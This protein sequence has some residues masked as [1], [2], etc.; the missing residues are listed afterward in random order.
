MKRLISGLIAI[1]LLATI[2][3]CSIG[4]KPGLPVSHDLGPI[5]EQHEDG[6][7]LTLNAPVWLWDERIRYRLLY[8][9]ATVIR[10]YHLDRW[11]APL[12]ALLER[13]LT[14]NSEQPFTVQIQLTQFEQQFSTLNQAHVV[15]RLTVSVFAAKDYRLIAKR[16]FNLSQNTISPDA[17]GAIA[18]FI[19]LTEQAKTGIQAWLKTLSD[20]R[21]ES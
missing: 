11:E 15:L 12:P 10:Y 6:L 2:C 16:S 4:S 5:T 9:D 14:I 20:K 18:G 19:T 8:Q 1:S 7:A 13:R 17:A 3:A 21:H